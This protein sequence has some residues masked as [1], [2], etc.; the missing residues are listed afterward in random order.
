VP[1]LVLA[2]LL[3][4]P[5]PPADDVH[6]VDTTGRLTPAGI[7]AAEAAADEWAERTTND[8]V[9]A[10]VPTLEGLSV[11]AFTAELFA[12]WQPGLPGVDNGV[13]V[14]V[15]LDDRELRVEA[16]SGLA[17]ELSLERAGE[18]ASAAL[19]ALRDDDVD[20]A[21][22]GLVTGVV[23]VVDRAAAGLGPPTTPFRFDADEDEDEDE[24]TGSDVPWLPIV[25]V[26]GLAVWGIVH[27]V[28]T[29]GGGDG[30]GDDGGGGWSTGRRRRS[31]FGGFGSSSRR[32]SGGSSRRS[33]SRSSSRGGRSS[34]RG[35]SRKW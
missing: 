6:V 21:V 31:S 18:L 8:I 12:S 27:Q 19:P 15:A 16:G 35:A 22:L 28:R 9:V 11:E 26:G 32:S 25:A 3:L 7:A 23:E 14:V 10:V 20:A 4:V 17:D 1:A 24:G 34:R 29:G 13:A 33:S 2:L 30:S 5:P